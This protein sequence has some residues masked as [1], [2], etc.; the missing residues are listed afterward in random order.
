MEFV[1]SVAIRNNQLRIPIKVVTLDRTFA[2]FWNNQIQPFVRIESRARPRADEHWHWP[3]MLSLLPRTELLAGRRCFGYA[4]VVESR[5]HKAIPIALSLLVETYSAF[6]ERP[7]GTF[8]WFA[9]TAPRNA[10]VAFGIP[11]LHD[12]GRIV[13]DATIVT[14]VNVGC[15]GQIYLHADAKGDHYLP[16]YY[17]TVCRL[18]RIGA[19]E[20]LRG[21]LRRN[22]GRYFGADS[23][24]AVT[25]LEAM[26]KWR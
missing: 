20:K 10:L 3:A 2:R 19:N 1:K 24:R 17:E 22:D 21:G 16:T 25:I 14:S 23:N 13:V 11:V 4:F 26:D 9:A 15:K 18:E 7:P 5:D 6:E 12:A 8:L